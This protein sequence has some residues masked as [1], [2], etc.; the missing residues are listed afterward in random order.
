MAEAI[1]LA[2]YIPA[3]GSRGR[4]RGALDGVKF[5]G[6]D[7]TG[8]ELPYGFENRNDV[9][10]FTVRSD[11]GEDG[12]AVDEDGRDVEPGHGHDA[13][14]H[15]L[16]APAEGQDAVVVHAPGDDLDGIGN[17]LT[18]DEGHRIPR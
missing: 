9:H 4:A 12:A 11:A 13:P 10:V 5:R 2:V 8:L 15:V 17:D 1:V 18:G 7:P 3:A 6:V 16:V 14:R